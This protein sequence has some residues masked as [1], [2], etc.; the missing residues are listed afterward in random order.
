MTA[1]LKQD[2][3]EHCIAASEQFERHIERGLYRVYE[4][5]MIDL[6]EEK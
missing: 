4:D 2:F 6:L 3:R 1:E 5:G